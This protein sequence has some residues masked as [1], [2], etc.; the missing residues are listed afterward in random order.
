MLTCKTFDIREFKPY[1]REAIVQFV[2]KKTDVFVN[3][4]TG[5]ANSLIY[6]ALLSV[7]D[8]I[9]EATGHVVVVTSPLVNLVKDQVDKLANLGILSTCSL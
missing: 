6:Q 8:S 4:L 5:C 9:F 7:F 3:L 2:Q 1:Q